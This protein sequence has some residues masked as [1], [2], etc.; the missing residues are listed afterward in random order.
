MVQEGSPAELAAS[1]RTAF[2]AD[3]TGAVVLTGNA[4][5]GPDGLT[6]VALDGGG[7]VASTDSAEGPVA[8]TVFPWDI[9]VELPGEERAPG[10]AQNRVEAEVVSITQVGNRVRLGLAAGQPLAAEVTL[11]STR[12]LELSQGDAGQRHLEGRRHGR[13]PRCAA[14]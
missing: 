5:A 1:P 10:S 7:S 12:R 14:G 4:G 3:F 13:G 9:S 2:V 8:A 6:L 11:A